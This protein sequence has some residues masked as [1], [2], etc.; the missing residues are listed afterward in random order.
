MKK[1]ELF[2]PMKLQ[3]FAEDEDY[4]DG[5]EGANETDFAD[6][7][8]EDDA[9]QSDEGVNEEVTEPQFD[10]DR[11][12][13]AFASMRRELE[14]AKRQQQEIDALYA[15]QY[16][17]Y[18][19]PE[20]GQPI[21]SARDYFEAM[22]AQERMQMRAQLQESNIDPSVIDNMIANSPAVREARAVTAELNSIRAGQMMNDDFK[23]V[24]AI[25]SSKSSEEDIVNDPSYDVVVGYVQS[26]PGV[27]FDEAYK[28]INFDRLASSKGAAAKQAAINEV[29]GKNHLSTGA[30][31]NVNS[32]DEEIPANMVELFKDRF[33]DKNM[34]ELKALYNKVIK[35]QKG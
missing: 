32:S 17:G 35:S 6:Q 11:A 19:N 29:K 4:V 22:A 8:E 10:T 2:L 30:A 27:R 21:T 13:A 16:G 34:K 20:T 5:D 24:L 9:G 28:L 31:V 7:S 12:N 1:K 14:A 15:R 18:T 26:H 3:F 25:D 23:K 33:P